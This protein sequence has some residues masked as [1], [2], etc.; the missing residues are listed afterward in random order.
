M[1]VS[2][3]VI[4]YEHTGVGS[5]YKTEGTGRYFLNKWGYNKYEIYR[6]QERFI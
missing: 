3:E 2:A 4:D 1:K 6:G 5:R